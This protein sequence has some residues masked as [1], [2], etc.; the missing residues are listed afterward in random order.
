MEAEIR[1]RLNTIGDPCSVANGVPMGLDDMG[2]VESVDVGPDGD[3]QI[4]LRLTSPTCVMVSHFKI[5]AE[6]LTREIPGVRNVAVRSD[7]GLDWSPDM[8]SA[9]ARRRRGAALRAR[10]VPPGAVR[11]R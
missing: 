8:M 4:K 3:V 7:L 5:Q 9:S 11:S 1:R 2:L 10:G 6:E